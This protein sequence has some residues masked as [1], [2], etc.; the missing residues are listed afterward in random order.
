MSA[1]LFPRH[2]A[3]LILATLACSFAGNHIAARIAFDHEAG[4]LLAI[5]CRSGVT[6]LVLSALVLWQRDSLR[7]KRETWGWQLL[8]GT[9]I[10]VQSFCIYSAVARI[11]VGLALLVVNLSPILLALLTWILGGPAPTRRAAVIMGVIL[12]GLMLVLDVPARLASQ[13]AIDER[14]VEGVLFSL[15]AAGVFAVALWVTEHRLSAMPGRVRS[16]LTMAV[17]FSLSAMVG[18]SGALPGGVGLPNALAGWIALGVLVTLYGTAFSLLFI[19]MP[20]LDIARNA[21]VMNMEPVAGMLFG[22]LILGQLLGALQVLGGL[23]VVGG[24]IAL[25]YRR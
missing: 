6:L 9:L 3:A 19:L 7:L 13:G 10:A 20:R 2:I 12:I 14:W 22:W 15:T 5:L 21:P 23:I 4:L 8:L 17:V 24:I 1:A 11:P 16:M 18:A 25:A